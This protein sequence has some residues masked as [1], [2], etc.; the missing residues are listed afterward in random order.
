MQLATLDDAPNSRSSC[1]ADAAAGITGHGR[2]ISNSTCINSSSSGSSR[3]DVDGQQ[4]SANNSSYA[5]RSLTIHQHPGA[6]ANKVVCDL[7]ELQLPQHLTQLVTPLP[8]QYNTA[9]EVVCPLNK[10]HESY[11]QQL[12]AG[13]PFLKCLHITD[14]YEGNEVVVKSFKALQELH[15]ELGGAFRWVW[16]VMRGGQV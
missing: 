13:L 8:G 3:S 10:S 1:D 9:G 4:P 7:Q 11:V 16:F 5:L 2:G 6:S 14:A 12:A 15:V